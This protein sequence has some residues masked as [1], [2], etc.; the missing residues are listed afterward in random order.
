MMR[1]FITSIGVYTMIEKEIIETVISDMDIFFTESKDCFSQT[2][3]IFTARLQS[4]IFKTE[5]YLEAAVIGEIGN[6]TFD[7]NFGYFTEFPKGVYCNFKYKQKYTILADYGRGVKQSLLNVLPNL[8]TDTEAVETA[9]TKMISG[10]ASEQ[11]GNGLKF[12]AET[13]QD[14]NWDLYFQSGFGSCSI[15]KNG[16]LFREEAVSIKGCL[17]VLN[18]NGEK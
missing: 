9:F 5:K 3:D 15:N 4:F 13:I 10:R 1:W 16:L 6:N 8:V 17:A 12:V 7:H 14:N 11:R 18:F 2:R